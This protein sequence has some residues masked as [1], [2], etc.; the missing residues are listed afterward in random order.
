MANA[1]KKHAGAGSQGKA[2]GSGAM[3]ETSDATLPPNTVLSNRDKAQHTKE[4]GQD[5]K[6]IQ[7]EQ[8]QDHAANRRS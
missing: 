5:G 1:N 6:N 4:R 8:R 7:T 3:S 2:D